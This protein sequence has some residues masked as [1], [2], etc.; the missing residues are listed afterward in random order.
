MMTNRIK[1]L[2]RILFDLNFN[3]FSLFVQ[4]SRNNNFKN[5]LYDY[6]DFIFVLLQYTLAV[7]K[8]FTSNLLLI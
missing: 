3:K 5:T 4:N 6:V 1:F 7:W 8:I 2:D